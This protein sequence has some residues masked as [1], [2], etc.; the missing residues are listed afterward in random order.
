MRHPFD[1]IIIPQDPTDVSAK[2]KTGETSRRSLLGWLAFGGSSL[3]GLFRGR[4][5]AEEPVAADD[6]TD[7]DKDAV[8]SK[9]A[10]GY[11]LYFVAPTDVKK[12]DPARRKELGVTGGFVAG[13]RSNPSSPSGEATWRGSRPSEPPRWARKTTS[14]WS[15]RLAR[16]TWRP[17]ASRRMVQ[18]G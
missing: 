17:P 16:P 5:L 4:A 8:T 7:A 13:W 11:R 9:R 15:T 6:P 3:L 1:G 14:R 18:P 2:S 12:F 10:Q